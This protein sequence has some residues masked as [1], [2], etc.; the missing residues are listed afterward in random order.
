MLEECSPLVQALATLGGI[1]CL[2]LLYAA[3]FFITLGI[4]CA[5]KKKS[6]PEMTEDEKNTGLLLAGFF[7]VV[8]PAGLVLLVGYWLGKL[9][10]LPFT[11][12]TKDDLLE[13]EKR[14]EEKISYTKQKPIETKFNVGD[15][16]KGIKGNPDGYTHLNEGCQCRVKSID[17]K[18]Q[19]K[20]VLVNHKDF[21]KHRDVIGNVFTAPARNFVKYR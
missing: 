21:A 8:F 14:L 2:G 12:V 19:M 18:G 5:V 17:E 20:V 4:Y 11:A 16:I 3:G 13:T 6:V 15:L 9:I 7:P 10:I 1:V